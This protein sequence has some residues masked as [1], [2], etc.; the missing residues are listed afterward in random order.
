MVL[1]IQYSEFIDTFR[2]KEVK[3]TRQSEGLIQFDGESRIMEQE[4]EVSV[5]HHAVKAIVP[6]EF[7]IISYAKN[8][9]P[10][11]KEM[12]PKIEDFPNSIKI[13]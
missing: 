13:Q 2:C 9:V 5:L 7:D 10:H 8:I 1:A 12:L 3:I 6:A 4:I 11:L